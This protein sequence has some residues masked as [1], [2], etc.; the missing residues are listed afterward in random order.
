[1]TTTALYIYQFGMTEEQRDREHKGKPYKTKLKVGD[2]ITVST[3]DQFF[4]IDRPHIPFGRRI[5]IGVREKGKSINFNFQIPFRATQDS[6]EILW[7]VRLMLLMGLPKLW[8]Q[9]KDSNEKINKD[10]FVFIEIIEL[11]EIETKEN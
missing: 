5:G 10:G 1:M 2:I 9:F 6:D 8:A 3:K 11:E 4:W 7:T